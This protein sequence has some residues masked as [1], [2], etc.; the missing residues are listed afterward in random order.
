MR[1]LDIIRNIAAVARQQRLDSQSC[2][3]GV[4]MCIILTQTAPAAVELATRPLSMRNM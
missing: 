1:T 3:W 2:Q 4:F